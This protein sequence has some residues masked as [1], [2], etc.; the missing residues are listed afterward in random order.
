MNAPKSVALDPA[1]A[2][3]IPF[4][5]RRFV[6]GAAAQ[7]MLAMWRP[8]GIDVTQDEQP[9]L[10]DA[11]PDYTGVD[12]QR[13]VRLLGFYNGSRQEGRSRGL[14]LLL[15]GWEGSSHSTYNLIQTQVLVGAGYDVFR[16]NLRD[17]GPHHLVNPYSLNRGLFLGTLIEEAATAARRVAELA[18]DRPFYIAGASMGGNFA[19]RLAFWHARQPFPNLVKVV[20][21]CPAINPGNATD[22]LDSH[23]A[24]RRYFRERW[25]RSLRGKQQLFGDLYDFRPLEQIASVRDMTDWMIRR[26]GHL[27]QDRF[28]SVDDYFAVY[29]APPS[30]FAELTVPV[31]IF[32]AANDPVIPVR[33]FY[34][35]PPHPLLKLQIHPTGGHCGFM[36]VLPMR[37]HMPSMVQAEIADVVQW[38]AWTAN[39]GSAGRPPGS[40]GEPP[41]TTGGK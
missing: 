20:A 29:T 34:Q 39:G 32:A 10:L 8:P 35:L 7:T 13:P 33:D 27:T 38:P 31:S 24:T 5:P 36:D 37:H 11:G 28:A 22:A 14:V 6:R 2:A 41:A 40:A 26:Y 25:L 16:L 19:L 18:G 15:H 21:A 9:L 23:P 30:S 4:T 3:P 12:P 17:H 1:L